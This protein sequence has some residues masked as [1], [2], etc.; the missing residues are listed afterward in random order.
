MTPILVHIDACNIREASRIFQKKL[1]VSIMGFFEGKQVLIAGAT[2]LVGSHL[3]ERFMDMGTVKVVALGRSELKIHRLFEKYHANP[4]FSIILQDASHPLLKFD[5]PFDFIINAIGGVSGSEISNSPVNI[6]ESNLISTLNFLNFLR[7]QNERSIV[8]GKLIILSSAT[9]YSTDIQH[10]NKVREENTESTNPLDAK[11][12]SYSETKR[13]LEVLGNSYYRQYGVECVAVRP[14]Y[15]YGYS[16]FNADTAFYQFIKKAMALNDI[17]IQ[18]S[19]LPRRDNIYIDDLIDGLLCV[20]EHGVPG[21]A[22]NI[23]SNGQLGN[24]AAINEIAEII[25]KAV[26]ECLGSQIKVE[27]PNGTTDIGGGLL[28]D[29]SKLTKLGWELKNDIYSGITKTVDKY[30]HALNI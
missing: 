3:V 26:N 4:R 14:S 20:C 12:A 25:V 15:I 28:L 24:F 29:N 5:T 6:I 18:A 22:Y 21:E 9:V 2:G 30:L 13:F 16:Y 19:L 8:K 27:Y 10:N 23:S 7:C 17:S 1:E 11:N